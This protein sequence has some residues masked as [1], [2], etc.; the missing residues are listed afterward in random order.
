MT[1]TTRTQGPCSLDLSKLTVRKDHERIVL[2]WRE[3]QEREQRRLFWREMRRVAV[4]VLCLLAIAAGLVLA[5]ST[6]AAA[7]AAVE[8]AGQ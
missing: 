8:E 3:A 6:S 5:R 1:A 4:V 7:A 2:T